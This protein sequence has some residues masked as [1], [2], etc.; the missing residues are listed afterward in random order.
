MLLQ[1]YFDDPYHRGHCEM[2]TH[3]AEGENPD[4]KC[5]IRFEIAVSDSGEILEAWWDGQGCMFC[6][7][8]ASILAEQV[9]GLPMSAL[10]LP[11]V[12]SSGPMGFESEDPEPAKIAS[13][14]DGRGKVDHSTPDANALAASFLSRL[15]GARREAEQ[16]GAAKSDASGSRE[17]RSDRP[18]P[19]VNLSE[20]IGEHLANRCVTMSVWTLLSAASSPL[21]RNEDDLADARQ[22]GGPSLREE[23]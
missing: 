8:S 23:C 15:E 14:A 13:V 11:I 4:S 3:L 6:E 5:Q 21:A 1:D 2:A 20:A 16:A 10:E 9:E 12:Q 22:F 7:G 19:M 17:A 18:E